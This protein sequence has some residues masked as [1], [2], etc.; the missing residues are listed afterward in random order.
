MFWYNIY[1]HYQNGKRFAFTGSHIRTPSKRRYSYGKS[2][3][4]P[5]SSSFVLLLTALGSVASIVGVILA[6]VFRIR[7]KIDRE[8]KESNRPTKD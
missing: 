4:R 3:E 6:I 1:G 7:D 5:L 8:M 2:R